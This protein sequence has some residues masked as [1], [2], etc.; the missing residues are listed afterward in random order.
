MK[1]VYTSYIST[2]IFFVGVVSI[3]P[4]TSGDPSWKRCPHKHKTMNR[5]LECSHE[6]GQELMRL[7]DE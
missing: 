7:R 4:K 6:K 5:A 2:G 1:S 3:D